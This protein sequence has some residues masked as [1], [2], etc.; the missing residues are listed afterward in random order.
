MEAMMPRSSINS[1]ALIAATMGVAAPQS[2]AA[3]IPSTW[4]AQTAS[5]PPSAVAPPPAPIGY[6]LAPGVSFVPQA[7]TEMGFDSNPN[8][9]FFNHRGSGFIRSGASFNFS[10]VSQTT[11]ANMFAAGSMLDYFNDTIFQDSLRFAGA[12]KANISYLVQPGATLSSGAFI[13]Y[14]GQILNK[15]RSAGSNVELAY[16]DNL[17]ASVIRGRFVDVEYLNNFGVPSPLLLTSAFNFN[18]TGANWTGLVG[19]SWFIQPYAE[20]DAARVN[21]TDQPAPAIVNR[22]ADDY[23]VKG[24]ARFILSPELATDVGWRWNFRDTD[25]YRVRSYESNFFDGS[26]T[27]RP[28]PFFTF[29]ASVERIIG[30][31]STAFAILSDIRSYNLKA[32]YAPIPGVSLTAGGGWQVATD[33]GSGV[34]YHSTFADGL[35]AWDYNNHV[36]FYTA[37]RYQNYELDWKNLEYNEVRFLA[38]VRITPDGQDLLSGESLESLL[39]RLSNSR[40]PS[41]SEFTASAGYSRLELPDMKMANVVGGQFFN[42]ATAQVKTGDGGLDGARADVKLANFAEASLP[43]GYAASFA[44][45]GFFANFQNTTRTRCMYG[46]AT[47]CAFVNIADYDTKLANNTGPFG[48]LRI[49]TDRNVNYYGV[50]VDARLAEWFGGGAKDGPVVRELFPLKAGV[51]MRG[52]DQTAKLRSVDPLV[53]D[54]VAYKEVLNTHYYGGFLGF[55][56]KWGLGYG[57]FAS[58]DATAGLY[59]TD[60]QYQGRY[61]GYAPVGG[62]YLQDSGAVDASIDRASFIGT[63]R[64]ALNRDLGWGAVGVFGQADYLSSVPSIRYNNN[65]SADLVSSWPI[66][67]AQV[68]THVYSTDAFNYTTGLTLSLHLQ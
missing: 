54:P 52:I 37:G 59:Y 22:N 31:P 61:H 36:Q 18:R 1:L 64:L 41:N 30:E 6:V 35:I 27:W 26:L 38:G 58:V 13:D 46:A 68:G 24:G 16:R 39:A 51:A 47:D 17:V 50:A 3:E 5:V 32:A 28:S 43:A 67:G 33:I 21:Y 42:K 60:T 45:S 57:W 53:S 29:A 40:L 10:S 20:A 62:G 34:H 49:S 56:N 65:D 25:D 15:I 23:H 48:N 11:I 8:Q 14:D 44:V 12:A 63:A 9:T 4:Q 66:H 2:Q 55:E 7:F 19:A